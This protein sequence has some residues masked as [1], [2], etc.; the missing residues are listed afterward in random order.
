MRINEIITEGELADFEGVNISFHRSTKRPQILVRA[1]DEWGNKELGHVLFN[2]GDGNELDPQDLEVDERFRGQGIAKIMYDFVKSKGY[3]INRSWD[4]TDAGAS[5]WNKNR[6]S[7]VR[8][9]ETE[10][11]AESLSRVAYH[12][13]NTMAALKILQSGQFQLSSALGSVEQQYMPKGRPYF[14][15]TTRTKTGGYHQGGMRRG[16]LFVLDGNWFNQHYK[17]GP[18]D[19]WGNRGTGL[20]ASE[21]EDRV[22]SAE[23]T[24]PIGGVIGV[25]VF[26]DVENEDNEEQRAHDQSIIREILIA[27]KTRG[28]PAFYYTDK[29]AWLALDTRKV[30]DVKQLTGSRKPSWYRPMRRRSYMQNWLELMQATAQNQ[31]SKDANN[32][33]YNLNYDYDRQDAARALGV[34]MSN[35]RKPDAGQE[36]DDAVKIIRYMQQN[37]LNTIQDFVNHIADKWNAINAKN[38]VAEDVKQALQYA[39]DAHAGQTRSGGE[40]YIGHPVRVAQTIKKYKQ[41]HN[42]DALIAAAYLHDTIEDTATTQEALH[43]L[44]GGLV[45]SLVQELTSDLEKIKQVGKKEYLAKKMAHELSS[46]GLV[47]KLADRLDNVQDI[48]TAKSPEWRARYKAVTEHIMDYIEQN[49]ALSDTHKKLVSLIREKLNEIPT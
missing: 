37:R 31:L 12:Y 11:L 17:S 39:T 48:A 27:A 41:S 19:Y 49:R 40:P 13:T 44:F 5:F 18:I 32:T 15:S 4:Q 6:G 38:K 46:W 45:A 26:F 1:L 28:I 30:A 23:P 33:R 10:E 29:N 22:Y 9:W 35:A 47:I 25:H 2:I 21:A 36:R 34:D 7:D 42:I 16:V 24:I 14:M 3:Q 43:D 20:R 8:V